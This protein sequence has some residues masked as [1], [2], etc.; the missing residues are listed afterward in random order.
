MTKP[1]SKRLTL[2][3]QY[4]MSAMLALATNNINMSD[5]HI[6]ERAVSLAKAVI[7]ELNKK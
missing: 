6:A 1:T 7:K 3:E 5:E 4:A 2:L